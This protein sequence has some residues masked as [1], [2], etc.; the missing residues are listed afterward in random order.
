MSVTVSC[1]NPSCSQPVDVAEVDLDVEVRCRECGQVF[2]AQ[3][4]AA[5][6]TTL[7][8]PAG[9]SSQGQVSRSDTQ[10]FEIA[11]LSQVA[12]APQRLGRFEVKACLGEGAFGR[13]YRAYDPQLDREVALKVAKT[14]SLNS[15]RQVERFLREARAAAQ[16]RH[17]NIVPL[18]E[19]GRDDDT[20]FIASAYIEGRT[21]A[22]AIDQNPPDFRHAAQIVR[23][24]A[25][26][27]AYAHAL[28]IVHRDVKPANVML[29]AKGEPL[30]MDFGLAARDEGGEKLTQE[31]SVMGTPA[32]MAPEQTRGKAEPASDQYSLGATLYELLTARPPFRAETPMETLLQSLEA[33]PVPPSQR[34]PQVPRDL[35]TICLKCLR[36]A[37]SERYPDCQALA[38][39]LRRWLE[40]EPIAARRLSPGERLLKLAW[41]RPTLVATY[42]LTVLALALIGIASIVTWL[43]READQESTNARHAEAEA[44]QQR[45]NALAAR[46]DAERQQKKAEVAEQAALAAKQESAYFRYLRQVDLAHRE[47]QAGNVGRTV[48]LLK[49][50]DPGP[51]HRPWEWRYVRRLCQA[52]LLDCQGHTDR[53]TSVAFSPDNKRIASG[54]DD[55]TVRVWDA[56]NG[57]QLHCLVHTSEV[58]GVAFSPDG[59]RIASLDKTVRVWDAQ[60]GKHLVGWESKAPLHSVTFSPDG[61]HILTSTGN[62]WV[63][64]LDAA[65]GTETR[66]FRWLGRPAKCLAFSPDGKRFAGCG[67]DPDVRIYDVASGEVVLDLQGHMTPVWSAAFSPDGKHIA[68]GGHDRTVTVWDAVTGQLGLTLQGHTDIVQSV[69]YSGDAKRIASASDDRTV[70]VWNAATGQELLTLRGHPFPVTSV[71]FSPDGKRIASASADQTVKVWDTYRRPEGRS[72]YGQSG[73]EC[74]AFSADGRCIASGGFD[75]TVRVWD[76]QTQRVILTI[77][78]HRQ[79]V[80]SLAFSPDGKRIASASGDRTLR[81]WDTQTGQ[82]LLTLQV[83]QVPR[84]SVFHVAFSPD[85]RHLASASGEPGKPG[86]VKLW[87]ADTGQELRVFRGPT[88]MV[89]SVAFGPDGKC[90]ACGSVDSSVWIWEVATGRK[91]LS[92]KADTDRI[93]SVAFSPDSKRLASAG[94]HGTVRLWDLQ[95]GKEEFIL[96]GHT[97]MVTSVMFSPDGQRLV[98]GS[99][100]QTIKVWDTRTGQEA[101]SIPGGLQR[102]LSVAFS[103]D[104]QCIAAAGPVEPVKIWDAGPV[105]S[106]PPRP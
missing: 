43:W 77:K 44:V 4:P 97:A 31:G 101:L 106:G 47:W 64:L 7:I 99:W 51:D 105:A 70:R 12:G 53:V 16:L 1:P 83:L 80:R 69:A 57:Q 102:V 11:G 73:S 56:Q 58:R 87:D 88:G 49:E 40:G 67:F 14:E 19:A 52:Y 59:Q 46:A 15:P 63:K 90:L 3:R 33:E 71:A 38:D 79:G 27:L 54:S 55:R 13:V 6:E 28:G 82:E 103:P 72:F 10:D 2:I 81:M 66:S 24:L 22:H 39:D 95:T 18:F 35:E 60:N 34:N 9:S 41:R 8:V 91:V 65:T 76:A 89:R 21:L 37:P 25:E 50:C 23:R 68:G 30:V 36:K 92:L 74:V 42:A 45:E 48:E 75:Q 5:K 61:R 94:Q 32:Y 62:G 96:R 86:Q 29:D 93:E 78:G 26:A 85:G 84:G 17:P 98:S 20:Y 100:D 104:G